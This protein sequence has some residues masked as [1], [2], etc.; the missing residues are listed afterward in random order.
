MTEATTDETLTLA[1]LRAGQR[2]RGL[3]P[4]Q[5]VTLIAI[6][7]IDAVPSSPPSTLST[8]SPTG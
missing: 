7:P 1:T 8:G 2:L 6:D 3:V 5:T 4:G